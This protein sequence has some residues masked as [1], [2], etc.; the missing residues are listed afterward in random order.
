[1]DL[2]FYNNSTINSIYT[3]YLKTNVT[4]RPDIFDGTVYKLLTGKYL[5]SDIKPYS[6]F[7]PYYKQIIESDETIKIIKNLEKN[8]YKPYLQNINPLHKI[9]SESYEIY[10][11]FLQKD[12][13]EREKCIEIKKESIKKYE[14]DI[15]EISLKI[16]KIE[17]KIEAERLEKSSKQP[18]SL[19]PRQ[20]NLR[21]MGQAVYRAHPNTIQKN[22]SELIIEIEGFIKRLQ[23]L[24]NIDITKRDI[25]QIDTI[26]ELIEDKIKQKEQYEKSLIDSIEF[27][28]INPDIKELT[29]E[30]DKK[31]KL[32]K[33]L[34]FIKNDLDIL[35][36]VVEQLNM[37]IDM[38]NKVKRHIIESESR[39]RKLPDLPVKKEKTESAKS[40]KSTKT[41][42]RL[43]PVLPKK[44]QQV[45]DF[46]N[47]LQQRAKYKFTDT[48]LVIGDADES[49]LREEPVVIKSVTEPVTQPVVGAR[50]G[51][52]QLRRFNAV[53]RPDITQ[54]V[55]RDQMVEKKESNGGFYELYKFIN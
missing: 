21:A 41:P 6:N 43:L 35:S 9:K 22:I 46:E 12:I 38:Y 54:S 28:K 27:Y 42:K 14:I 25:K 5:L 19:Q 53:Y 49:I 10:I 17:K 24:E 4:H 18:I 16:D 34:S 7:E 23:I 50:P 2:C 48:G 40:S 8:K 29:N 32:N 3:N 30:E 13:I 11:D 20:R 52:E 1:M 55:V 36:N 31:N 47:I 26:K 39:R 33:E 37:R 51:L 45:E 44:S 15:E